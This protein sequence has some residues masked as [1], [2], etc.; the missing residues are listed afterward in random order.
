MFSGFG[1]SGSRKC[2][3]HTL[4][5]NPKRCE[6]EANTSLVFHNTACDV[7]S[8]TGA[9]T[10]YLIGRSFT[11]TLG[12]LM[13]CMQFPLYCK[14]IKAKFKERKPDVLVALEEISDMLTPSMFSVV[15][16]PMHFVD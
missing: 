15:V 12:L 1:E 6:E 7:S 5:T 3:S 4:Q 10:F 14:S 16:K 13:F 9:S 2:H 8:S 11:L